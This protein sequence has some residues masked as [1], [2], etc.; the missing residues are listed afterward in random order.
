MSV[1]FVQDE[2][3]GGL[4]TRLEASKLPAAEYPLLFNGRV[5]GNTIRPTKAHV[6]LD[7][8][9]GT[10]RQGLYSVGKYL[11]LFTDGIAYYKDI[12]NLT[13]PWNL[14]TA[15]TALSSSAARIYADPVPVSYFLGSINYAVSNDVADVKTT[16]PGLPAETLS[17]LFVTDGINQPRVIRPDGTWRDT[18]T[19]TT[20]ST[21]A[22]E[23]VPL[24][25]LPKASGPK[26][27]LVDPV[28][29]NRIFQSVSGRYLDFV[30]NRTSTGD[31][32]GTADTTC[33][34]VDY[35]EITAVVSISSSG[36]AAG[37]PG[38][39]IGTLYQSY[40]IGMDYTT[41]IFGEPMLPAI[42]LFPTGPINDRSFADLLGDTAFITQ[43][44]IQAFNVTQQFKIESNNFPLGA[45]IAKIL[46]NP[47]A[48]TCACNY[49]TE[50]L[51][52]VNTVYGK[53]VLIYDCITQKFVSIDL[54]FGE[55]TDFAVNKYNGVQKLFFLTADGNVYQAYASDEYAICR[56][57]L[58]EYATYDPATGK[59]IPGKQHKISGI[60]LQF[61]ELKS[62]VNVQLS[63]YGD[64]SLLKVETRTVD[65]VVYPEIA[66]YPLPFPSHRQSRPVD[67]QTPANPFVWK[68][69]IL[70]EWDK[71]AELLSI[72]AEGDVTSK[73]S[74][75]RPGIIS[76]PRHI[77]TVF[78]DCSYPAEL[79]GSGVWELVTGLTV[80]AWYSIT[81][82]AHIGAKVVTDTAFQA[83]STAIN[84][85]GSLRALGNIKT[86]LDA[87]TAAGS[88]LFIGQGDHSMNAGSATDAAWIKSL[89]DPTKLAWA[90]GNHDQLTASGKW[91]FDIIPSLRY[92][93]H[94]FGPVDFFFI[95]SDASEPD[96]N[97]STSVQAMWL[98]N[99]L[100]LSTNVFR[101]VVFHHAPY[102]DD[103][104]YYPGTTAMRWPF[105]TWGAD[106]VIS[107]HAH[108]YQRFVVDEV[109]Y[110]VNGPTGSS[111]RGFTPGQDNSITRQ[112]SAGYLK[113]TIDNFKVL[114][115]FIDT[116]GVVLDAFAIYA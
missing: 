10:L 18:G 37:G 112:S 23:Y 105:K 53:A 84:V 36:L 52:S 50:A 61:T 6:K 86:I 24:G 73:D 70:L 91:F 33:K 15:W 69:G 110:I 1:L 12:S 44:G 65:A 99:E 98:K 88:E 32:G 95:N 104:A 89:L 106:M 13:A 68:T 109:P 41:T 101:I 55:V 94:I 72:A 85:N 111:I 9:A 107:G 115:E 47:Q 90:P 16:W 96:G 75:E 54:G 60:R 17:Y 3:T 87:M 27:F 58:G 51:F 103:T 82:T 8:P 56:V 7:I 67:F 57:Y 30:I 92:Y 5:T 59:Q 35:N 77:A 78:G 14:V 93:K 74:W 81:G 48:N 102:T 114:G 62:D 31:K 113:L 63:L 26:L 97:T 21:T 25:I 79:A 20:W 29:K 39:F 28:N 83:P 46:V 80:G 66:P 34:A 71:G 49:D 42:P 64:R 40:V 2:F 11:Y 43:T 108:A 38:L 22:P 76:E 19:Y 100:E 116:T 45:P 4:N